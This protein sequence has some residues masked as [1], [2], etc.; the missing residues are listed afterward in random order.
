MCTLLA[1]CVN[2]KR[3]R[4]FTRELCSVGNRWWCDCAGII[5]GSFGGLQC[6]CCS[7]SM[8][9][10]QNTWV[11][12]MIP[13]RR[14]KERAREKDRQ[15]DANHP[16]KKSASLLQNTTQVKAGWG[17]CFCYWH[18]E[19]VF[20]VARWC[21]YWMNEPSG[22]MN[23]WLYSGWMLKAIRMNSVVR[24]LRFHYWKISSFFFNSMIKHIGFN[25][26]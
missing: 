8:I 19:C 22:W 18:V 24:F 21:F 13:S 5:R 3:R 26:W 15:R 17:E 11:Y 23:E 7:V 4:C 12:T 14:E 9:C 2:T 25:S 10:L 6:G 1:V 16:N 20:C